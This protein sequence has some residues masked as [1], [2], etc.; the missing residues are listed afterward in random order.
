MR[1]E[2]MEEIVKSETAKWKARLFDC[3]HHILGYIDSWKRRAK[4]KQEL[5]LDLTVQS[6]LQVRK[7]ENRLRIFI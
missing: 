4:S 3:Y 2:M 7:Q 6:S 5:S 1:R